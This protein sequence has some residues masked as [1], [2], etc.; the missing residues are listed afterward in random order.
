M[1]KRYN[2]NNYQSRI[3]E[4]QPVHRR[5]PR[6]G[7]ACASDLTCANEFR[8][9]P[10]AEKTYIIILCGRTRVSETFRIS[11]LVV[12]LSTTLLFVGRR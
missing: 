5:S 2:N 1:G 6:P 8:Q 11:D 4:V 9:N 3:I 10:P 12:Q 7:L